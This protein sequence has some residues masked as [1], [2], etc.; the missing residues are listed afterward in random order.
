MFKPGDKVKLLPYNLLAINFFLLNYDRIYTVNEIK[1]NR[2]SFKEEPYSDY[3]YRFF[4]LD[5]SS[6]ND[7]KLKRELGV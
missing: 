1:N 7:A 2:I 4:E 3:H 6:T 5:V